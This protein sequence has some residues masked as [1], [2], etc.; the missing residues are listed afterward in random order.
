ILFEEMKAKHMNPRARQLLPDGQ[1]WLFVE[2]GGATPAQAKAK[3]CALQSAMTQLDNM[4]EMVLF[5]GE[6]EQEIV[7]QARESGLGATA[8]SPQLGDTFPGWEDA[9][10]APE[11]V[12]DYLREFRALMHRF[13]YEAALYGHFGDGCV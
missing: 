13:G 12:D 10:V 9:A 8:Q 5:E 4:P 1:G 11:D 2:F 7:W 3:A 6:F